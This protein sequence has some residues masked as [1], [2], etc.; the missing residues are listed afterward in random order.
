MTIDRD[1][2]A[3]N[4]VASVRELVEATIAIERDQRVESALD[5]RG[6]E[7]RLQ[8]LLEEVGS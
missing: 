3:K 8:A 2:W 4:V 6:A 5:Q 1:L 7:Q